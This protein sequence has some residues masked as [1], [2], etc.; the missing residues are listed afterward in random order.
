MARRRAAQRAAAAAAPAARRSCPAGEVSSSASRVSKAQSATRSTALRSPLSCPRS[1]ES[2]V[3][4]CHATCRMS[5]T[6][7]ASASLGWRWR[8]ARAAEA[9]RR[10]RQPRACSDGGT[11]GASACPRAGPPA[12]RLAAALE[13]AP[14]AEAQ[15]AAGWRP[16]CSSTRLLPFPV[17][18]SV[19]K[20]RRRLLVDSR[21]PRAALANDQVNRKPGE[22]GHRNIGRGSCRSALADGVERQVIRTP[23][24]KARSGAYAVIP[25]VDIGCH[26]FRARLCLCHCKT[27]SFIGTT[28]TGSSRLVHCKLYH[29][30][31]GSHN[32]AEVARTGRGA[33]RR[34]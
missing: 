24:M 15:A 33:G 30:K 2:N 6:A 11:F 32:P 8:Q 1:C 34:C 12:P 22:L 26:A 21:R 10:R 16:R 17:D 29:C 27:R 23:K 18:C 4:S 20:W 7:S 3:F 28:T 5:S 31:F 14:P 19:S 9:P 13:P 25:G